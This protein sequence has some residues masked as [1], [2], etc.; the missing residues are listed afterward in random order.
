MNKA[1]RMYRLD[2]LKPEEF[3]LPE[4]KKAESLV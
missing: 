4:I 1:V 2:D 3:E